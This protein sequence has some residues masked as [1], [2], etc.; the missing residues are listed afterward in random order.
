MT[1]VSY[2]NESKQLTASDAAAL[3]AGTPYSIKLVNQ[4]ASPFKFYVYQQLPNQQSANVFSLAW[5]CSP[6]NISPGNQIT[7]QWSVEYGF[8]WGDSGVIQPGVT[9]N[10]S[11][12]TQADPQ[13]VNSTI[14]SNSPTAG[15]NLSAPIPGQPQG[16]L[17]I[18]DAANVPSNEFS[19]GVS[20]SGA[21]TFV[22]N[23]GPNL[24][25]TF[26]PT[27]TYWIAAGSN[28]QVGTVM[29]ITTV[30]QNAQVIFPPNVYTLTYNLNPS[31]QWVR[32]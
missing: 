10:A 21:G 30:N 24:L 3:G 14:F 11:G 18:S 15:P 13:S 7:F 17:I 5:F 12:N 16:S 4:S 31:N 27:P 22:T 26:T 29:D 8:V 19:V 1:I 2:V 9:F 6:Y 32:G 25:H 28:V 23:A 20:M